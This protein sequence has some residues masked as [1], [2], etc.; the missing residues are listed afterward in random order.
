MLFFMLALRRHQ[1]D[2][3]SQEGCLQGL[4]RHWQQ[5]WP[6]L[7]SSMP[8]AEQRQLALSAVRAAENQGITLERDV[9]TWCD[10]CIGGRTSFAT[11]LPMPTDNHGRR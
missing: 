11:S 2:S 4:A 7:F 10:L 1:F 5:T 8:V 6:A 3:I 9:Y